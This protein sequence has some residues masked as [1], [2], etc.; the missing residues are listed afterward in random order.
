MK[1]HLF[2]ER[3]KKFCTLDSHIDLKCETVELIGFKLF[4]V[5]D[6]FLAGNKFFSSFLI[7]TKDSLDK[8]STLNFHN[9]LAIYRI[10]R[11]L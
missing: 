7:E 1:S 8:V 5:K 3:M 2:L 11:S 4:L 9:E 6:W 10:A